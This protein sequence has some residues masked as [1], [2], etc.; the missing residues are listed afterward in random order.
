[1]AARPSAML[2]FLRSFILHSHALDALGFSASVPQPSPLPSRPSLSS[3]L[4]LR[5]AAPAPAPR[6]RWRDRDAISLSACTAP[7]APRP[8]N[9]SCCTLIVAVIA[10]YVLDRH[11]AAAPYSGPRE[12][13]PYCHRETHTQ[14]GFRAPPILANLGA[15]M[16]AP[17]IVSLRDM[18]VPQAS[19]RR[20]A[21]RL[22]DGAAPAFALG[23]YSSLSMASRCGSG[24]VLSLRLGVFLAP[25]N[26][27]AF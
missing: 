23:R 3:C 20:L 18:A 13:C 16:S 17:A 2:T 21:C 12:P 5:P 24:R 26:F 15:I 14:F 1:M 19:T 25:F 9:F 22:P 4:L 10:P 6:G 8:S 27:I 7:S 11:T